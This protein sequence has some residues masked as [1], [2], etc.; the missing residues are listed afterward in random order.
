MAGVFR[1]QFTEAMKK[2]SYGWFWEK[3]NLTAV[4]YPEIFDITQSDAA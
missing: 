3:Y 1:N 4:K 2:D